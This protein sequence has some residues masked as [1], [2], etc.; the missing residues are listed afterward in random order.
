MCN[1]M[2]KMLEFCSRSSKFLDKSKKVKKPI[3]FYRILRL[4]LPKKL[5]LP[6]LVGDTDIIPHKERI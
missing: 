4:K 1:P 6:F 3:F 5:I 2:Y